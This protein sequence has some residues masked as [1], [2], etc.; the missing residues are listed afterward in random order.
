MGGTD[1]W[2]GTLGRGASPREGSWPCEA[3]QHLCVGDTTGPSSRQP[4]QLALR[5]YPRI[6][7]WPGCTC[8]TICGGL[9]PRT[10][11]EEGLQCPE[12]RPGGLGP[13]QLCPGLSDGPFLPLPPRSQGLCILSLIKG[14]CAASSLPP[15]LP[16][17]EDGGVG[18]TSQAKPGRAGGLEPQDLPRGAEGPLHPSQPPDLVSHVCPLFAC[19]LAAVSEKLSSRSSLQSLIQKL[20]V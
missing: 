9:D 8:P 2:S 19:T 17:P 7:A 16:A 10:A 5:L 12:G 3:L 4:A 6:A 18:P 15:C 11:H 13:E 20:Q 1:R 14:L